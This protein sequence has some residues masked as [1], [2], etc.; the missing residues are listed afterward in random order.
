MELGPAWVRSHACSGDIKKEHL[1]I[2]TTYSLTL[3]GIPPGSSVVLSIRDFEL[4]EWAGTCYEYD[5]IS[6]TG[7]HKD[8]RLCDDTITA[9]TIVAEEGIIQVKFVSNGSLGYKGF[10]I[11]YTDGFYI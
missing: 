6:S 7:R 9:L 10:N 4:E 2:F 3:T 8:V 5:H 11:T 1:K